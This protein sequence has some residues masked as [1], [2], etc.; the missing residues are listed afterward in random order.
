MVILGI[1]G[2]GG[3]LGD[4]TYVTGAEGS[5]GGEASGGKGEGHGP[6]C[7]RNAGESEGT[8]AQSGEPIFQLAAFLQ[9]AASRG[10]SRGA[11]DS[12][13]KS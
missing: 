11:R 8:R 9:V 10:V 6:P 1:E 7:M 3:V 5:G 4:L 13:F 12:F 2:G